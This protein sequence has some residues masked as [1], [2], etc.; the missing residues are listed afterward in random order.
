MPFS[1]LEVLHNQSETSEKTL[2]CLLLKMRSQK[3]Q[4][5]KQVSVL[6]RNNLSQDISHVVLFENEEAFLQ[7]M[8]GNF[9][10]RRVGADVFLQISSE[11]ELLHIRRIVQVPLFM[12][13]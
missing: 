12:K 4:C 2:L 9:K 11:T 8:A 13:F 3:F 6:F 10:T 7:L 5:R 1:V